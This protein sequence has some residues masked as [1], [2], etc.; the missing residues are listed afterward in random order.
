MSEV[1]NRAFGADR[2]GSFW[3]HFPIMFEAPFI[4]TTVD[5]G[6]RVARSTLSGGPGSSGALPGSGLAPRRLALQPDCRRSVG[7]CSADRRHRPSRQDQHTAPA[8]RGRQ[9][10]TRSDRADGTLSVV[11]ATVVMIMFVVGV[12]LAAKAIRGGI[13]VSSEDVPAL[14]LLFAPA[15]LIPAAAEN[16]RQRRWPAIAA[17]AKPTTASGGGG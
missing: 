10:T 14:S 4:M 12:V 6:T 7:R 9:P 3:D 1:L 11:F 8:V 15:G 5:T 17:A 13:G 2:F 16:E